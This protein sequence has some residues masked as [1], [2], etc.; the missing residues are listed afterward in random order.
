MT[1][2]AM[3]KSLKMAVNKLEELDK[4]LPR[5]SKV[6]KSLIVKKFVLFPK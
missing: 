6:P 2:S 3:M 5:L 1:N 4:K